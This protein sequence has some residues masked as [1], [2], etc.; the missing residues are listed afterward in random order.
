MI[1]GLYM[2][3]TTIKVPVEIK[4]HEKESFAW[5][6][7]GYAEN[8]LEGSIVDSRNLDD[9][10]V[11]WHRQPKNCSIKIAKVRL[12][13]LEPLLHKSHLLKGFRS[14]G[15]NSDGIIVILLLS[16]LDFSIGLLVM[17]RKTAQ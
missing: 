9:H 12:D 14:F 17:V 2:E 4:D 7:N 16:Y 13:G 1:N 10:E 5:F 3:Q 6:S 15:K 11:L 8:T